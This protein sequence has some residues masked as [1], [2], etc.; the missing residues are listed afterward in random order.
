[1]KVYYM[2]SNC[3]YEIGFKTE[4]TTR[5]EFAMKNKKGKTLT[6]KQ[7]NHIEILKINKVYTKES[8]IIIIVS[9]TIFLLGS[10]IATSFLLKMINEMNTVLG[11]I[12]ITSGLLIPVWIYT[13]LNKED[14][15]RV[16]SFNQTY[17]K[18]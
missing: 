15:R 12:V 16:K 18:E 17:V 1:M 14:R 6:C 7:C 8:K 2:C 4:S 3:S 9:M 10:V 5:V 11:I 13:I